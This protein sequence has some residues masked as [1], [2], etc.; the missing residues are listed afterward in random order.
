MSEAMNPAL[1]PRLS[2]PAVFGRVAVLMGGDAAERP[3]SLNSG[4]AV[5]AALQ[6]Q[7]VDAFALDTQGGMIEALQAQ[8]FDRAFNV[9]HG[10]GGEDGQLQGVMLSLGI[11][12][13]GSALLGSALTMDKL[14]TKRLLLGAGIQ[15]PKYL[16]LESE[17]DCARVE[18]ELGWPV[19]VKPVLEG[20]S[21]GMSKVHGPEQ[22]VEA[23]NTARQYGEVFAEQW[24]SGQEFT[25]A[26]VAGVMLPLIRIEAANVFY[27]YDAKYQ[28]NE[29][30]YHLPC[31]LSAE[32]EAEIAAQAAASIRLCNVA[33]WGRVDVLCDADGQSFVIELNTTPGMTDHSLVPKAAAAA[34]L[35]FDQLV[36]KILEQTLEDEHV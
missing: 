36:W 1:K 4:A 28:S 27:D 5:L 16:V 8:Q 24:I 10:R 25:A 29:T 12:L 23:W 14:R 35:G 6:R 7:G 31:G 11:P 20:S 18:A 9:L 33:G 15:T 32:R 17:K 34:G 13:T 19:I 3:V 2:D 30:C 26:M 21:I 22:I